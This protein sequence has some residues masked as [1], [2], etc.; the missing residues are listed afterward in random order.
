LQAYTYFKSS[1]VPKETERDMLS[2]IDS[3]KKEILRYGRIWIK[4]MINQ[5][6]RESFECYIKTGKEITS[7]DHIA[8]VN[9]DIANLNSSINMNLL[10]LNEEMRYDKKIKEKVKTNGNKF[11][12]RKWIDLKHFFAL[13][14]VD[15]DIVADKTVVQKV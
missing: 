1:I 4:R 12:N 8:E 14:N 2:L 9:D 5:V 6:I 3:D 15:K 13:T 7:L 11:V 10:T